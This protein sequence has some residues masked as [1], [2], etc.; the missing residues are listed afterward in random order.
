MTPVQLLF[1]LIGL[2]G[3]AIAQQ[4]L[5]VPP[6]VGNTATLYPLLIRQELVRDTRYQQ[7]YAATAFA[8]HDPS[9][10]YL[11]RIDF[12]TQREDTVYGNWTTNLQLRL[13]TTAKGPDAL[14]MN[15]A[16][17]IGSDETLVYADIMAN[18]Y[19]RPSLSLSRYIFILPE[20][21]LYDPRK[22]NLLVDFR[23]QTPGEPVPEID[24]ALDANSDATD[25]V[26]RVYATS[27]DATVATHADTIGLNTV[28][29]FDP[30]PSL[31]I[32][33]SKFGTPTNRIV[34]EWPT[35]PTVFKLQQA[36]HLGNSANWQTV[37]ND[38]GGP[39][40]SFQR[41]FFP[42]QS[43]APTVFFRLIWEGGE[44]VP[45]VLRSG[46]SLSLPPSPLKE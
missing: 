9:Q 14:S 8:A 28:F 21:F 31:R 16:E 39:N 18:S 34:I 17:N 35:Q 30:V 10:R 44:P 29:Y 13:S 45:P 42:V 27:A 1:V 23:V 46:T 3:R 25:A 2:G 37:T 15:F 38:T 11:T 41:Y 43:A 20:P 22:G 4:M 5:E 33:T 19:V 6:G 12:P 26:S 36:T 40:A 7:V 24:P 32:Y